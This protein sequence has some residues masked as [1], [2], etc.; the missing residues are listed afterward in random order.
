MP[1]DTIT[2]I[3]ARSTRFFFKRQSWHLLSVAVMAA[4]S[5]AFAA[6]ALGDGQ[7][8]GLTDSTWFW[9]SI[10]LVILHQLLVWLVF[11]S[12]LG[13][14]L[15][16]RLFGKADLAV[17]GALFLPLL[18]ARPLLLFALAMSDRDSLALSRP[19][20]LILG[21]ILLI[22]TLYT[23]YSV[24]HYFGLARALGGDHFRQQYR[25]M[26]MVREGAFRW[27]GNA[28]YAF[29]FLGLW[30]IALF[31]GSLAALGLALFQHV[32]IW[33][34]YYCTEEPDMALIYGR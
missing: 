20:A 29:A 30:S 7:W 3:E 11:R 32:T 31:T 17:W 13:W 6:P 1:S 19:L 24:G 26:P 14:G 16:S 15:F 5:W 9:L 4:I 25:H 33:A 18:A 34:H 10:G 12:Q 27:S 23:L 21:F 8:L 22:P 2:L 28:M